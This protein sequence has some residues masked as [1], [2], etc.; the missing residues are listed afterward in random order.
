MSTTKKY[1]IYDIEVF[2]NFFCIVLADALNGE[3]EY[4]VIHEIRNDYSE[5]ISFMERQIK[6]ESIFFGFNN[7]AY[8]SQIVCHM[9]DKKKRYKNAEA[10]DICRDLFI[11]SNEII[12]NRDVQ[13]YRIP[14]PEYKLLF[15]NV[16]L[17]KLNHWDNKA[18]SSSL[19]WI[20]YT[21]DWP[22]IQ[23]SNISFHSLITTK[24]QIK[25]TLSYCRNDVRATRR[26]F[27]LSKNLIKLRFQLT[28]T[29]NVNLHSASEPKISKELFAYFLSLK[30]GKEPRDVKNLPTTKRTL[31]RVA[32]IILPYVEF[33]SPVF[34][35]VLDKFKSVVISPDNTKGE[36]KHSIINN[37]VKTDYGLGGIH[38]ARASGIYQSDKDMII[39]TSDVTSFYPNLAIRNKWAP[40]HLDKDA[41]CDQY[42]WFFEERK[43]IPKKDPL[44]YVYKLILNSTYGLSNDKH[45]FLYDPELT[46]RITINGQLSLTMLYE[47]ISLAIPESIPL[48]QNT[49][50]L[51][52]II[53]RN[54]VDVYYQV[55][56]EWENITNL[57][58]EHDKY[59]KLILADVNNYIAVYEWKY[60]DA[61]IW[62]EL[63]EQN[64]NYVFKILPDGFGYAA[65]KCKGR[66]EFENLAL[67]KNKS[68]LIVSKAVYAYFVHNMIPEE[69]IMTNKNIYDFCGGI[70]TNSAYL[71]QA[72]YHDDKG[73]EEIVE[74]HKIT[75]YYV[76]KKGC[77]IQKME[78]Q[79]GKIINVDAGTWRATIFNQYEDK[80][81]E[82]YNINY[83][84]YLQRINRE[85]ES[86]RG[87]QLKLLF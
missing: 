29:Y 5:F 43:K 52:T 74:L 46:M 78:K 70:R 16:D 49:D 72:V 67:H 69:Y 24:E 51:E 35:S 57:Q 17:F 7:L 73:N 54:K 84:Y 40:G 42:E 10:V 6:N 81:F 18:K 77:K 80:P 83:T 32:D 33:K 4:F 86:A 76:S 31:I 20:E 85:I 15:R 22:N 30:L 21:M 11:L 8:D 38:G 58:L 26:I 9:I 45:S 71:V 1:W 87:S 13:G 64:P 62:Y 60:V 39:M 44:N 53:P 36:F 12:N 56:Q 47:M 79:T 28:K 63:R 68:H 37:G 55:C 34:K 66:F 59:Q 82:E 61:E 41:F 14:Y 50:G 23:E 2:E 3:E 48:M 19:K 25:E 27:E 65:T 75:R